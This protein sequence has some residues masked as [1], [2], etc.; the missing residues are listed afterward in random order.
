MLTRFCY[1]PHRDS[2]L[3]AFC[4]YILSSRLSLSCVVCVVVIKLTQRQSRVRFTL[5]LFF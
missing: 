3:I 2:V 1:Q 5:I 4:V